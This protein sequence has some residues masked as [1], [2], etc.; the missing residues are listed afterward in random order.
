VRAWR[1]LPIRL[2]LPLA[3]AL[4]MAIVLCATGPFVYV[5]LRSQILTTVDRA[6]RSKADD[7][8]ALVE[9]SGLGAFGEVGSKGLAEDSDSFAQILDPGG[10][11]VAATPQAPASALLTPAETARARRQTIVVQAGV[12]PHDDNDPVRLLATRIEHDGRGLVIVVGTSLEHSQQP[13]V[14]VRRLLFVGGPVAL[15]LAALAGYLLAAAA[16]RPVES[17]RRRASVLS[18]GDP[19][20]RLPIGPARDE[21][22]KLGETLNDMLGRL[23]AA[24]ARER[25]FVS[26]ASHELRTPLAILRSG[27]EVALDDGVSR[28]ELRETVRAAAGQSERLSQLAEDLLVIARADEHG[29]P[30]RPAPQDVDDLLGFVVERFARPPGELAIDP[31]SVSGVCV[32]DRLRLEQALTNMV[33]NALRF[34][35][36][37]VL[38]R[39]CERGGD[40]ELHVT[41]GGPGFPAGFADRA[42]ERFT[43]ADEARGPGGAGLGLAVVQAIAAAHG[44]SAHAANR[45][46]GGADVWLTLPAVESSLA[47]ERVA[48][49]MA[50]APV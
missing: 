1:R 23:E 10:R 3:F 12:L 47:A 42:F 48:A 43:R 18:A 11:L 21:I 40:I 37:P 14:T 19:S 4:V 6:L 41:D 2:R 17:M 20:L 5:Q 16:L 27:L 29:L 39:A 38:L 28:A 33:D 13:L 7:I 44:G 9:R 25:R 26:D 35:G 34:G 36:R 32:A 45:P 15:L 49:E 50:D 22:S 31:S 46:G 8:A 24:L 30:I